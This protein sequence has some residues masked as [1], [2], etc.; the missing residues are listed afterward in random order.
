MSPA[1]GRTPEG[2]D[3]LLVIRPLARSGPRD[4]YAPSRM[5]FA[6][7]IRSAVPVFQSPSAS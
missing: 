4:R 2:P 1:Q 7:A 3:H 5:A 6:A